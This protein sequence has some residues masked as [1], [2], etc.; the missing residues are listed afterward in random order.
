MWGRGALTACGLAVAIGGAIPATAS[1]GVLGGGS[2]PLTAAIK[3]DGSN[4]FW[5]VEAVTAC[6]GDDW[7]D[8]FLN[9]IAPINNGTFTASG[10]MEVPKSGERVKVHYRVVASVGQTSASGTLQATATRRR[11]GRTA[12]CRVG[13][14]AFQL[15]PNGPVGA[16]VARP[17]HLP[18]YGFTNQTI[19]S[20]AAPVVVLPWHG[21]VY[22]K[23]TA[24]M[25]CRNGGS[26]IQPFVNM[27][28]T[29]RPN[30]RTGVF[31]RHERF[32][33]VYS[34]STIR[35]R[36]DTTGR[37]TANGATGTVRL[38]ATV[39]THGGRVLDHC[40]SLRQRWGAL[41]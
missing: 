21:R 3:S 38:R 27:T 13:H 10:S 23:W 11:H 7:G 9:G 20:T 32:T 14:G 19:Y 6:P 31:S 18:L 4:A 28:P 24:E 12:R 37:F 40:D 41:P 1:A 30:P 17:A 16:P 29:M 33:L 2:A 36:A 5:M 34:D 8:V 22:L 15:R 35:Y 25:L 26:L 39:L